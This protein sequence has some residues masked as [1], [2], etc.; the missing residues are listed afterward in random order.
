MRRLKLGWSAL[1]TVCLVLP[2]FR[3]GMREYAWIIFTHIPLWVILKNVVFFGVLR[4]LYIL[5]VKRFPFLKWSLFSLVC[6]NPRLNIQLVPADGWYGLLFLPLLILN[7]P[8]IVTLEEFIFRDGLS[9][10]E[11]GLLWSLLFGFMH[12]FVGFSVGGCILTSL[13]G[14]WFTH[15]YFVG[16]LPLSVIHHSTYNLVIFASICYQRALMYIRASKWMVRVEVS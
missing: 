8:F 12:S 9:S 11:Q 14:V 4:S 6:K 2:L 7:V 16:G 5:G 13:A 10:W 15:Q 3:S 1:L